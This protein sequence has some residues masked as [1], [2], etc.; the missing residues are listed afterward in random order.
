MS[1]YTSREFLQAT[2]EARE[3]FDAAIDLAISAP[4]LMHQLLAI[5]AL[6]LSTVRTDKEDFYRSQAAELQVQALSFF[7][8][9]PRDCHSENP[10]PVFLFSSFLGVHVMFDTLLFRP[11]DFTQFLDRFIGCLRLHRGVYTFA[12]GSWSSLSSSDIAPLIQTHE[13]GAEH[14]SKQECSSL[15]ALMYA[16]DLGSTSIKACLDSIDR[17]QW[18]FD[19]ASLGTTGGAD[20]IFAWPITMSSEFTEL[21][22]Q[23]RPEALAVLAHYGVMLHFR[24]DLWIIKDSGLYLIKSIIKYLGSYW[25]HW[26]EFPLSVLRKLH[27]DDIYS[28]HS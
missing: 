21:L 8:N 3:S 15:K 7:N 10:T 17:L 20:V 19:C 24:R 4:F 28:T 11:T 13:P 9:L 14:I 16:A 2:T 22:A 5:G 26:L 27:P 6:H 23:R 25:E 18:V 12:K 1:R